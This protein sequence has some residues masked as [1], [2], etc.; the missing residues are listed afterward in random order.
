MLPILKTNRSYF[1][2][3]LADISK[4]LS[5]PSEIETVG[6]VI[7]LPSVSF[8]LFEA[9]QIYFGNEN[10]FFVGMT[11]KTNTVSEMHAE[12]GKVVCIALK[13]Q[14]NGIY[15]VYASTASLNGDK[16]VLN[17]ND[18]KLITSPGEEG[19]NGKEILL[20]LF[21]LLEKEDEAREIL[22]QIK[23]GDFLSY[24]SSETFWNELNLEGEKNIQTFSRL[25]C[26]LQN[27]IKARMSAKDPNMI[28]KFD[29]DILPFTP[30]Y[31]KDNAFDTKGI[32][33]INECCRMIGKKEQKGKYQLSKR[34]LTEAE[35]LLVPDLP[36]WHIIADFVKEFCEM[37][38][39]T[40][41][42]PNPVRVFGA[43][44]PAGCGKTEA[45]N[46]IAYLLN[47]PLLR[48]TCHPQFE[49]FD[50]IGNLIP[51][52]DEAV[53]MTFDDVR[54]QMGLPSTEEIVL[55]PDCAY[56]KMYHKEMGEVLDIELVVNQMMVD[57]VKKV[58]SRMNELFN[59]KDYRFIQGPLL[60][61]YEKGYVCEIQEIGA[62]LRPGVA[63]GL[64]AMMETGLNSVYT[65]LTGK[66]V[67][68]H[69]DFI[70]YFT[71]NDKYEGTCNLNQ[72]VLSRWSMLYRFK[73]PSVETM[74]RRVKKKLN[75]PS[76]AKMIQM[77]KVIES[78]YEY[79]N[80]QNNIHDGVCGQRE[81]ENWAMMVMVKMKTMGI[82]KPEE[83]PD[84]V[85]RET[86]Q[87]A[88]VNKSTQRSDKL[89]LI[90]QAC[91]DPI[92]GGISSEKRWAS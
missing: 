89:I 8:T 85:Y 42:F 84:E 45:A 70:A 16:Y 48:I 87:V 69:P 41:H 22:K 90:E 3:G 76:E 65:L 92:L 67:K 82:E 73:N 36:D 1:K 7:N 83:V 68:R 25:I 81:L 5:T 23:E 52:T 26:R 61:A 63:V 44:G 31:A 4:E 56:V 88:V 53:P 39:M 75:F 28:I 40:T 49:I 91:V 51:N 72:S 37:A 33:V 21:P 59:S 55:D 64:N 78:I 30:A 14:H 38:K 34:I 2:D 15:K 9:L 50:F 57:L 66:T 60:D 24:D 79:C 13:K 11:S 10:N 35:Q 58:T 54:N 18:Y 74:A 80:E 29:D 17:K 47:L 32:A 27:N 62:I 71:S 86:C 46:A 43:I 20:A 6:A 19:Y 77:A 12:N